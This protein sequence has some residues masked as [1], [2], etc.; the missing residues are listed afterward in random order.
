[1]SITKKNTVQPLSV[2]HF[3][4]FAY[5]LYPAYFFKITPYKIVHLTILD[6]TTWLKNV[7]FSGLM[8]LKNYFVFN[9]RTPK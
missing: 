5:G 6:F 2:K 1:M 7:F 8:V 4:F 9:Y 3:C